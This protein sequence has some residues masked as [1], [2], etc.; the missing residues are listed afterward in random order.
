MP[1][2]EDA[3]RQA[4]RQQASLNPHPEHVRD[5]LFQGNDFFDADD[6]VQVKYEM[7]RR[8]HKDE[9]PARLLR[10]SDSHGPP[11]TRLSPPFSSRDWEGWCLTSGAPNTPTS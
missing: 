3:K 5:E 9:H 10:P 4:L 11:S 7:L 1:K 6:L 8:V 2:S